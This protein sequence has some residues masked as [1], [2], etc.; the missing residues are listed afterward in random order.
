MFDGHKLYDSKLP[1]EVTARLSI[2]FN[3]DDLTTV[4][5]TTIYPCVTQ[6]RFCL[7]AL[8]LASNG[9][10]LNNASQPKQYAEPK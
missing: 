1:F 8:R 4:A 7:N 2:R 6:P 10:D 3:H 5:E 9:R